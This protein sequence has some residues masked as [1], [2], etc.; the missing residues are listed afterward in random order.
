MMRIGNLKTPYLATWTIGVWFALQLFPVSCLLRAQESSRPWDRLEIYGN[1]EVLFTDYHITGDF[2][3]F[4]Q[5]NPEVITD[6]KFDQRTRIQIRGEVGED[7][8]VHAVFDDSNFK[9]EDEKI[10]LNLQSDQFELALGRISLGLEGTRFVL[11][12]RKAL[13]IFLKRKFRRLESSFLISRSEGQEEREEFRGQGLNREYILKKSPIVPG[14]ER[15]ILDEHELRADKD[16]K[17]DYEGGSIQLDHQLLPVE[18]T[19]LLI[20]EYES[21]REGT[22]F[23]NRI[24]ATRHYYE[25]EPGTNFGLSYAVEKDQVSKELASLLKTP[26]HQLSVLGLDAHY[27]IIDGL[28]FKIEAAHSVEKQDLLSHTLPTRSANALDLALDF[29]RQNHHLKLRK[30]RIEPEFRSVGKNAFLR[31]GEDSGLVGDIEQE[32]MEYQFEKNGWTMS[33][34]YR[35][36]HTNLNSSTTKETRKFQGIGGEIHGKFSSKLELSAGWNNEN[37]PVQFQGLQREYGVLRKKH[38]KID[39]PSPYG[40]RIALSGENER[41]DSLGVSANSYQDRGVNLY[42]V[43]S[44]D[45]SWDYGLKLREVDDILLAAETSNSRDH[46]LSFNYRRGREVQTQAEFI[47]RDDQDLKQGSKGRSVSSGFDLRFRPTRAFDYSMKWKQEEKRRVILETSRQDLANQLLEQ[48]RKT[49][50]T[51][52]NPIQSIVTSQQLRFRQNKNIFHRLSYRFR[53]ELEQIADQTLSKNENYHYDL[54]WNFPW[55]LRLRYQWRKQDRY[56]LNSSLDR[57]ANSQEVE[58]T[59]NLESSTTLTASVR[60]NNESDHW[61]KSIQKTSNGSLRLDRTLSSVFRAHGNFINRDRKG[62]EN[63]REWTL[64]GGLVY[65]PGLDD[66]RMG[67]DLSRG[68]SEQ[69][70]TGIAGDLQKVEL[71]MNKELFTDAFIEGRYKFEKEGPSSK[72]TGYSGGT[73]HLRVSMD[74]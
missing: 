49:Y 2:N 11:N 44:G 20:I 15:V 34:S 18:N 22:A 55:D 46:K 61:L 25:W 42:S 54:K 41:K 31:Q 40:V 62:K 58:L 69:K 21:S 74:F 17:M 53:S 27:S 13:G 70:G 28:S 60:R 6:S 67:L 56:N 37:L 65:T 51:P 10:L 7:V 29:H 52:T 39:W 26:P 71:S 68:R 32:S 38:A 57:T 47:L 59:Q 35:E 3:Q 33:Q 5:K 12:N 36:S 16:Y 30:E 72:G 50:L 64:G 24:F 43:S 9:E 48:D 1:K 23:K 4:V 63:S 8:Q 66:L 45:F 14:S 73:Y 19:S